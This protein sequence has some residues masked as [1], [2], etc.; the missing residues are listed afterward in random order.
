SLG[1]PGDDDRDWTAASWNAGAVFGVGGGLSLTAG[2]GRSWRAPTLFELYAN[3]PRIGEGR[4]D[5]GDRAL[6]EEKGVEIDGGLRWTGP[7]ARAEV[8]VFRNA[9]DDFIVTAPTGDFFGGLRVFHTMQTDA[10][11]RGVEAQAEVR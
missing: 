9:I 2:V 3:G 1:L 4:Y 8:S 5:V 11:L 6:E 7:T 10:L